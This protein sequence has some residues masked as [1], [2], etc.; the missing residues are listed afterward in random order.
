MAGRVLR[1]AFAAD[2]HGARP[3][4]GDGGDALGGLPIA[5]VLEADGRLAEALGRVGLRDVDE[6]GGV[7]V[8][9]RHLNH[10]AD[11]GEDGDVGAESQG[12]GKQ[13]DGGPGLV[14]GQHSGGD[15]EVLY[16]SH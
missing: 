6:L 15:A 16:E 13:G 3:V 12:E 14:L 7:G 8:G 9:Q 1:L 11:D 5:H 2:G 10:Q 4:G